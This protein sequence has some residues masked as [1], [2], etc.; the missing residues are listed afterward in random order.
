MNPFS[1]D[2]R[3]DFANYNFDGSSSG[4]V[5]TSGFGTCDFED[6]NERNTTLHLQQQIEQKK[7]NILDSSNR[8]LGLVYESE[9]IGNE[10][11]QELMSQGEQLRR[12]E[13]RLD[14]IDSDLTASQ[15]HITSIKSVFG[16]FRNYFSRKNENVE[17][18]AEEREQ[19]EVIPYKN[20]SNDQRDEERRKERMENHPGMRNL[21][22][23]QQK[24]QRSQ[25][26]GMAAFDSQLDEN[27]GLSRLKGLA[28]GLGSELDDQNADIERITG[29][30]NR[31][32]NKIDKTNMDVKRL[33]RR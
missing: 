27:L 25:Q 18:V 12:T 2:G 19:A 33:L 15:R 6:D 10:T 13:R 9:D 29:K 20:Q 16:G 14:K 11:A 3:D 32:D 7:K 4:N 21:P 1:S 5:D 26:S 31:V 22:Y 23:N 17:P 30:T 8:S 28:S 24:Q